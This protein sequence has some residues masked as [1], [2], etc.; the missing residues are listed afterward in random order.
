MRYYIIDDDLASRKI[1]SRI[2]TDNF[3]GE[4]I[5]ESEEAFGKEIEIINSQIDILLIDLLL[6]Q[7]DGIETVHNLRKRNFKGK[8]IMISQVENKEMVAK[9]YQE[10]IEYFIHKPINL[11]EV[12]SIINKVIDQIKMENSLDN[13]RKSLAIFNNTKEENNLSNSLKI[14]QVV[15]NILADF[16]ILG[17][18]GSNDLIEIM[19]HFYNHYNLEK[20]EPFYYDN[21][22]LKDVYATILI[23][24]D[25]SADDKDLKAMEQ[26]LR[27]AVNQA[28]TNIASL[29]LVDY[30][31]PKF[32]HY[33]TKFFDFNEIRLK[34]RELD[35]KNETHRSKINL[36]KFIVALYNE[37][38]SRAE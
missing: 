35:N 6:P 23:K 24:K 29:G 27:R 12:S 38:L 11:V 3:L 32:E 15:H 17:E 4:V 8:I 2:I 20:R 37:M 33:A 14:N 21:L 22:Q 26:R 5:S 7:Q 19:Q 36:K 34:M 16:G 31:H 1:L 25:K 18:S 9:A 30:G 13:I 10:G 28:M